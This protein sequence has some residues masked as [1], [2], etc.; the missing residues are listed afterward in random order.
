MMSRTLRTLRE[1]KSMNTPIAIV[2][3]NRVEPLRQLVARL[4]EVKPP[5]IY[6]I[7]DGPRDGREGETEKVAECREFMKNM[8]WPCEVKANFAEKNMG[9][10]KR[11]TSGL[12][13]LFSN[14]E[15]AIIL[16]DDCIPALEFFPWMETM[17]ERYKSE[18][19]V[20]SICGTNYNGRLSEESYDITATKYPVFTGWGTWRRAWELNDKDLRR[21]KEAKETHQLRKW[22]G[23]V[24][25]ECYWLYLLSH[26]G[27]SWGYRWSFTN[28]MN[29]GLQVLPQRNLMDNVGINSGPATH[30][31]DYLHEF[32]VADQT[33]RYRGRLP[34]MVESNPNLDKWFA[35]V[36]YSKSFIERIKWIVRKISRKVM[37]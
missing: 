1:K 4:A 14:E 25:E 8:P 24:R 20:L 16:E 5:K 36:F 31:A 12:D 35:D 9:C 17:L 2:F 27:S 29:E 13:W 26:V 7:S 15:R 10:R 28:F 37:G 11:V 22:L 33:W 19:K 21:L 30:T 6:L 18:S 23:S 32:P 34:D 3:F